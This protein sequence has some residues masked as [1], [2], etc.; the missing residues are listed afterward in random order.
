MGELSFESKDVLNMLLFECSRDLVRQEE[1]GIVSSRLERNDRLSGDVAR[2]GELFLGEA[3]L[4]AECGYTGL[5]QSFLS[6]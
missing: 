6:R 1:R 2:C 5:H 4:F 3:D